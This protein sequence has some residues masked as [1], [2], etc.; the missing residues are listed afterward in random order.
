MDFELY[1][2]TFK[3]KAIEEQYE[4]DYIGE[5][6]DY[7]RKLWENSLPIIYDND[8]LAQLLGVKS[9]YLY[10]V[11]NGQKHY[12]RKFKIRKRNSKKRT[13]HEPL[14]ILKGIQ[15]WVLKEILDTRAVS[16]YT[17]AFKKDSSIKDNA[18]F[19]KR[20]KYI[21]N[22]DIK[23]YF[24]SINEYQVYK[25]FLSMGYTKGVSM[26]MSKLC[27]L[28]GSLPQGSPTSPAL[29]NIIT[30]SLDNKLAQLASEHS[31]RLRYSRYADDITFSGNF[32]SDELIKTINKILNEEG[33]RINNNKTRVLAANKQQTVTGIVVNEKLQITKKIRKELR[34]NLYYISKFGINEHL[35]IVGWN[36]SQEKYIRRL[37][38]IAGH[39][40]FINPGDDEVKRYQENLH[41]ILKEF[42]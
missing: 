10:G 37:L 29:S 13:I 1:A 42:H 5:C 36:Q 8:H 16:V 24:G 19:H 9:R 18:K 22:I 23:D 28:D 35:E 25:A 30:I 40:L 33:F 14:P 41:R 26:M 17:K 12:Y 4:D 20:Q 34:Q 31:P 7:A 3:K 38:G 11:A 2:E 21:L 32:R 6:L 27:T 39:V 15:K